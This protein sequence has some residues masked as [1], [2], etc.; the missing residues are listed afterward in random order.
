[1]FD[2]WILSSKNNSEESSNGPVEPEQGSPADQLETEIRILGKNFNQLD[3]IDELS[4]FVFRLVV[5]AAFLLISWSQNLILQS[6]DQK[7]S[8][9]HTE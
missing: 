6:I 9:N 7:A 5:F 4:K 2:W 3:I 1:M 8:S